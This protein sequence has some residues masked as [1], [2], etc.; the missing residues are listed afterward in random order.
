M[1]RLNP[2]WPRQ[3]LIRLLFLVHFLT[4]YDHQTTEPLIYRQD[5]VSNTPP[6]SPPLWFYSETHIKISSDLLVYSLDLK[7][8]RASFDNFLRDSASIISPAGSATYECRPY[9]MIKTHQTFIIATLN[10]SY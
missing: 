3:F 1:K 5:F 9:S 7:N 4:N 6:P 10:N 8:S 2:E